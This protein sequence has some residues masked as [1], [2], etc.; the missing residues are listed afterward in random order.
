MT[1]IFPNPYL[2]HIICRLLQIPDNRQNTLF[3]LL[4]PLHSQAPVLR[5]HVLHLFLLHI[6]GMA[7]FAFQADILFIAN[8]SHGH[9][10]VFIDSH[11]T[12]SIQGRI[13]I[14]DNTCFLLDNLPILHFAAK[15]GCRNHTLHRCPRRRCTYFPIRLDKEEPH[16]GK[17]RTNT[18]T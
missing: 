6:V 11:H 17:H 7:P 4:S 3:L 13:T 9:D 14:V 10:G 15:N 16:S 12:P 8:Y 1:K 2:H 18:A 5:S